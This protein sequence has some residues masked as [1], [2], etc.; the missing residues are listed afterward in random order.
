[1]EGAITSKATAKVTWDALKKTN[2]SMDWVHLAK[3]NMLRRELD[4]LNFKD[5]ESIDDFARHRSRQPARGPR[6]RLHRVRDCAQVP[7]GNSTEVLA[8][9]DGDRNSS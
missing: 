5:G 7:L 4:S 1:M 6:Q 8:N 9:H 2:L 3:V